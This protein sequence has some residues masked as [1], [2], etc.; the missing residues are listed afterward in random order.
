MLP[1][2]GIFRS[3]ITIAAVVTVAGVAEA[4][5]FT[6]VGWGGGVQ[7]VQRDL[8]FK[9]F[10][11]QEGINFLEDTYLGGWAQFK[12]MQE[13]GKVPWDVVQVEASEL[14]R[15]CDEGVFLALDWAKIGPQPD[16]VPA[17]V[18]ECGVG[19]IVWSVVIG[20]NADTV[21]DEPKSSADFFDTKRWPGKRGMRK[22]PKLNLELALMA[23]GVAPADVYKVLSTPAGVDR[24][25]AKLD[26][27]K[28]LVQWWEA[29]AQAPE[30]LIS[31]DVELSIAYNGRITKAIEDGQNLKMIWDNTIYAIDSWVILAKSPHVETAY[32][33]IKFAS[34][35][36]LQAE[37]TKS[38]AYGPTTVAAV[39]M[40]DP[41]RAVDLPAGANLKTGLHGGSPEALEFWIDNQEELTERWNAWASN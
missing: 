37:Y 18:S 38:Y 4:R 24:A 25:F 35:P 15:G 2:S 5:D 19:T 41:A 33:Y 21:K 3:V 6:V 34:Q 40:V 30:W 39:P 12:A 22:G 13:T 17:A 7:D 32:K 28:P 14:G 16:F 20:Y 9:P 10:A 27:V 23:D 29:G 31:G 8:Y 1:W 36:K 26:T 11:K